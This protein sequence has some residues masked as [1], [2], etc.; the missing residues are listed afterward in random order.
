MARRSLQWQLDRIW[1]AAAKSTVGPDCG[2]MSLG[3]LR[4][5]E[6]QNLRADLQAFCDSDKPD[7]TVLI[8]GDSWVKE[9]E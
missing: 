1:T 3:M 7:H 8:L 4:S 6:L 2:V 9:Y 5:F